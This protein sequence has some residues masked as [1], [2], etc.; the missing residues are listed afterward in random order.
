MK[1]L[2]TDTSIIE[3][4]LASAVLAIEEIKFP[5]EI[6]VK[7]EI[8]IKKPNW[9][10]A[11]DV[12][13]IV[14]GAMDRIEN[15]FNDIIDRRIIKIKSEKP[16][17]VRVVDVR[18]KTVDFKSLGGSVMQ[19]GGGFIMSGGGGGESA[20]KNLTDGRKTVDTAGTAVALATDTNCSKV[21][22]TAML[23]NTDYVVVGGSTVVAMEA[24][25]R[26]IPLVAGQSMEISISNLNKVYLD[27]VVSGEGVT[28]VYF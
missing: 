17:D 14:S 6:E 8:T 16:L 21:I 27:V 12:T 18:G 23:N 11:I 15:F 4:R 1:E 3:G 2:K 20:F 5:E 9:Y 10:K 13:T 25:R 28:F 7:N 26:G 24:T 19:Q 22:I